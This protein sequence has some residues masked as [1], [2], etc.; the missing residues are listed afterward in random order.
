MKLTY[1][2][3]FEQTPNNYSAYPPDLPGCMSTADT[4]PA[5]QEA[6]REAI[7]IFVEETV[8][9]GQPLP[10]PRMSV[11]ETMAYHSTALTEHAEEIQRAFADAPATLTTT[12]GTVDV[13]VSVPAVAG[14]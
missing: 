10:M 3:V 13:E 12:F 5:I 14:G 2:V 1:A 6:A 9:Q 4:W 7:A 8:E 11:E